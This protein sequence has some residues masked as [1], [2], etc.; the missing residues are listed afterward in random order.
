[1]NIDFIYPMYRPF[2]GW[3]RERLGGGH[4]L[5]F[6]E[7][8]GLEDSAVVHPDTDVLVTARFPAAWA[9]RFP[10]LRLLHAAGA[11]L[12]KIALDALAPDV[13]VC[14][15]FGHG[16]AVAEH[17]VMVMLALLRRLLPADR[18]LR[19]G[20]WLNPAYDAG[21]PLP[22]TL[23]GRF[24]VILGTGEIGVA[25]AKLAGALGV[26]CCGVNRTGRMTAGSPF[27]RIRP[28]SSLR[29]ILPDADF[30]VVA[31]P[32]TDETRGLIGREEIA[33]LPSSAFLVNVA[34]GPIV[35]ETALFEAL[36]SR[37]LAGAALDVW[38]AHPA[39]GATRGAP[40]R[41]PFRELDHVIMTPH[42]SGFTQETFRQRTENI[43]AN[44]LALAA[45]GE[46]RHEVIRTG[47]PV[48]S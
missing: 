2:A 21:V 43:A 36:H 24:A 22:G 44:I 29:E 20:R 4:R 19:F 5:R 39:P 33:L 25:T 42:V 15:T 6:P 30:L 46:L 26:R 18:E 16:T 28:L 38:Y 48:A 47:R 9:P 31:L 12:D 13:R 3:L 1:M 23:A 27:S 10:A 41:L 40:S 45:G 37:V 35:D 32:L 14:C 11:G 17:V 7:P 34:R 8:A